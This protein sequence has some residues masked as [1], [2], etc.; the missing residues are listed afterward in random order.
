MKEGEILMVLTRVD[1]KPTVFEFLENLIASRPTNKSLL[2]ISAS[3]FMLPVSLR[4]NILFYSP[5]DEARFRKV[6]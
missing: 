4:E 1:S 6:L 2:M 5:Y 3:H